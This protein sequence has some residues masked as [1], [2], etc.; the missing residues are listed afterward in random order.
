MAVMII[1]NINYLMIKMNF[2]LEL[3]IITVAKKISQMFSNSTKVIYKK[4]LSIVCH[5]MT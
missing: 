1:K 4:I 3:I 2:G 5:G